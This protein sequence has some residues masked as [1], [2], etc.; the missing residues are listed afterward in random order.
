LGNGDIFQLAGIFL[1]KDGDFMFG[2]IA[3][4]VIVSVNPK[5]DDAHR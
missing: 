5:G 3:G 2:P 1:L 4:N